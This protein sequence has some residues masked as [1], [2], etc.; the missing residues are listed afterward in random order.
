MF[1]FYFFKVHQTIPE[2]RRGRF[3]R[4]ENLAEFGERLCAGLPMCDLGITADGSQVID[5]PV[6]GALHTPKLLQKLAFQFFQCVL[7]VIAG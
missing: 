3:N 5:Q 1:P 4:I 6:C 7:L 2:Y